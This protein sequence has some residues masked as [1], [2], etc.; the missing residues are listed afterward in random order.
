[1][2]LANA[3]LPIESTAAP[4]AAP[5]GAGSGADA[6]SGK[7]TG[8][9]ASS[10][11]SLPGAAPVAAPLPPSLPLPPAASAAAL[12]RSLPVAALSFSCALRSS[13]SRLA[14]TASAAVMRLL[15]TAVILF[16]R[17]CSFNFFA[18]AFAFAFAFCVGCTGGSGGAGVAFVFAFAFCVGCTGGSGGAGVAFVFCLFDDPAF[19]VGCTG[20]SGVLLRFC[21]FFTAGGASSVAVLDFMS[22]M[23][24]DAAITL[25][26]KAREP[27]ALD[28]KVTRAR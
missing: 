19:C 15:C 23:S 4:V 2:R 5:P 1:M 7:G 13:K 6:A 3:D 20:G 16:L 17:S 8:T 11:S 18:S 21:S 24:T 22:C 9:V 28:G 10:S 26:G 27:D 25:M 14:R 12:C